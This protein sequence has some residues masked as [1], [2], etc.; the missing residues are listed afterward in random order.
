M[1]LDV[2]A[3]GAHP[4]DV[5]IGAGGTIAK[6]V[7]AGGKA[8]MVS[9]T[10]AELSSNGTVENRLIEADKAAKLLKADPVITLKFPDR[11]LEDH[12][13]NIIAEL[14]RLIRLHRPRI[15]L[16]PWHNDRHPDHGHCG[17]LTREAVFNA[18]IV[19]YLPEIEPWKPQRLY[20]YAINSNDRPHFAVDISSQLD[21]KYKALQAFQSQFIKSGKEKDTP[22][23]NGFLERLHARDVQL[24]TQTGTYAAEGF[25][26]EEPVLLQ[27][28]TEED[29]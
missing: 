18:G 11:H 22:L 9:L 25:F 8:G 12:R 27:S 15:V 5:E 3:I 7:A 10:E 24:G 6:T 1:T 19:K 13:S 20:F 23:N 14:C 29:L 2:L 16:A 21:L 4:D 26:A 17:R 28:I